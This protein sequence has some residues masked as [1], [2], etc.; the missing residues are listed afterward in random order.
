MKTA[1]L[2]S[3]LVAATLCVCL[4]GTFLVNPYSA[5]TAHAA[6]SKATVSCPGWTVL[7]DS[8]FN[9][10][11]NTYYNW[12]ACSG[13]QLQLI[14]QN[15]GNFVLYCNSTALWSARTVITNG[16]YTPYEVVFQS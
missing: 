1:F 3:I 4:V 10:G 14:Y 9:L 8:G 5:G 12:T 6:P 15:D 2:K 13:N 11:P 7:P 16:N